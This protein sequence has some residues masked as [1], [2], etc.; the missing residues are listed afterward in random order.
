MKDQN[1]VGIDS[2]VR[3]YNSLSR[4][5]EVF[6][7]RVAGKVNIY[8]CGM[9]VYDYCH[10]GHARVLVVFDSVV[11][12]LR[13]LG[14]GVRYVRNITDIDDKIIARVQES[15]EAL[16]E[17]T[18][19]FINA[20]HDDEQMINILPP[21]E[22][23]RAT[24]FIDEII[25][26][27]RRLE[28]SG[29]AYLGTNGDVY[30]RV[31]K[32]EG[33]GRLSGH[34]LDQLESGARIE[35]DEAK[36]D[37]LDF[38][39]WKA[40]KANEPYWESPWGRGRPGWHI[41]C[42]AMSMKCLGESFDI[43]AG[44]I[45]LQFPHH[46]NEIAQ[47]EAATSV[48]FVHYWMHNGYVQVDRQKMSKSLGNF[49][50]IREILAR[51]SSPHRMGEIV[52][53]MMLASHYRSPLNFSDD[54]L[55]NARASLT[56]LYLALDKVGVCTVKNDAWRESDYWRSFHSAMAD[57]FNTPDAISVLFNLTRE[58]NR[59]VDGG[60]EKQARELGGQLTALAGV[61]GLLYQDPEGFLKGIE[62]TEETANFLNAEWI[63]QQI[64]ER[65]IARE[66]GDWKRA[67]QIR[68][69]LSD[70]G[71]VLEDRSD[72]TTSWRAERIYTSE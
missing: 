63:E 51:D 49:F 6:R 48:P 70:R 38:V 17:L 15:G 62:D 47:S 64:H 60:Q 21:D 50:T 40:W 58:L 24:R 34:S 19:R 30:Y 55:D 28:R 46:E 14:V 5:K 20:M 66:E 72:G 23:P 56:R 27:I 1:T 10:L 71:V 32:F 12:Y 31:R 9:T 54:S 45:D 43:H 53:F 18:D 22:E 4:Q 2:P 59:M 61:L 7:T 65:S 33:Y 41:E 52:R 42:S 25:D 8:V 67:D 39:L 13:S 37:P 36:E 29:Y 68:D 11:R 26:L 57:D 44:G 16:E 3:I 35:P 69:D